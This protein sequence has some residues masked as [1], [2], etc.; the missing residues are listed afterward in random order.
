V[1]LLKTPLRLPIKG[2]TTRRHAA[3]LPDADLTCCRVWTEQER[4]AIGTVKV[5]MLQGLKGKRPA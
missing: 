1:R 2:A 3:L 5:A 4:S